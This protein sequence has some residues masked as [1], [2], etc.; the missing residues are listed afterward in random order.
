MTGSST[1]GSGTTGGGGTGGGTAGTGGDTTSTG[2]GGTGGGGTGGTAGT[3]GGTTTTG[4]GIPCADPDACPQPAGECFVAT[5]EGGFC[6]EATVSDGGAAKTQVPGDCK[7]LVCQGGAVVEVDDDGD[8]DDDGS[9][10]TDDLCDMGAPLHPPA[11]PGA[12][13]GVAADM[14]CDG[15]GQCIG[16]LT[17]AD[18]PGTDTD[19]A[20]RACAAGV[21]GKDNTPAGT[22]VS[23]Q[24]PGDCKVVV[25]NGN[26]GTTVQN[27]D[28]DLGDDGNPCSTDLCING[29]P[30]AAGVPNGTPCAVG[31]TCV[32]GACNGCATPASC[33]GVDDEC[34]Q[35]TCVA[36]A[37][38][39]S[40][41]PSGTPVMAQ[42]AAD[43][44][45]N[46]C[47]GA[48]N[49]T[50]VMDNSDLPVDGIICT[51]DV[52]TAGIP[53]HPPTPA[54]TPCN[55]N[56]G[57]VCS[58]A[59]TCVQC[60][61]ASQCPGVD[62]ECQSRTCVA[63]ACG[64]AF[65]PA[66]GTVSQQQPG[67]CQQAV[68]DGL[69]GIGQVPLDTDLPVDNNTC[70]A[71]V[72]ASG[73]AS[74]PGVPLGTP[75]N[76]GGGNQC[77]GSGLCLVAP[78]VTAISPAD[79]G[80]VAPAEGTPIAVTFTLPMDAATVGGQATAGP[81][82][83]T[84]QVSLDNFATCVALPGAPVLSNGGNTVTVV[85]KPGLLVNRTYRVRVTTAAVSSAGFPL[86]L[87]VTQPNGFAT[88]SPNLCDG[89]VVMSQVYGGGAVSSSVYKNDFVVLHN[90]GSQVASIAGWSLQSAPALGSAW[91][92]VDLTGSIQPGGY[93]LVQ[94][95]GG[96]NG[97]DLPP[98]D[99]IGTFSMQSA[100]GKVALVSTGTLLTGNCPSGGDIVDFVGYGAAGTVD[101]WE[102]AGAAPITTS[103]KSVWRHQTACADVNDN[104]RDFS[105]QNVVPLNSATV[106]QICACLVHNE[107]GATAEVDY[108]DVQFPTSLMLAPGASS[109]AVYGQI[110]EAGATVAAGESALI[111]AQLGYGPVTANPELGTGFTWVNAAYNV[112]AGNNDEYQASFFA[113]L[114]GSY[115]YVYRMSLDQGVSWTVCD[116]NMAPD[117]GAGS[118]PGLLFEL[119][120]Q[121]VLTVAP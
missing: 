63:K 78:E 69:G 14:V 21:C 1:T 12:P 5:C 72:C 80:S 50:P 59:G 102:G 79:S 18:C 49:I 113:P 86:L 120:T 88:T 107:S 93:Y 15:N 56:G 20:K 54:D 26:G 31:V 116:A 33:P 51:L 90:R 105:Q 36:G 85:A 74:N 47:D 3:G 99:A 30:L 67:D 19:C 77:N 41:T 115:R 60:N 121:G 106:P 73:V 8:P 114:P 27:D 81:C 40:F 82:T 44:L 25:C 64:V 109:G 62:T 91:Q 28:G 38:G 22:P 57:S 96:A 84:I 13:C 119:E 76:Q 87:P 103:S 97:F 4:T 45:V 92:K 16:C 46:A 42:V 39:V 117:F 55:Q 52:C 95:F 2:G 111:R 58:G 11:A 23:Q 110:Y 71:D 66:G 43:C 89:S 24:T 61:T 17:G 34:K 108:C 6:G 118:D 68:C 29:V 7:V 83:G 104:A 48:G 75:C 32:N 100:Q 35:R 9:D 53:G 94:L 70:T 10:C 112:Q 37:C 98:A 101:C 65:T